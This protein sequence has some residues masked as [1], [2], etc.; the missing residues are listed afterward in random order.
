MDCERKIIIAIDGPSGSGKSTTSRMVSQ[1]LKYIYVDTGAMYRATAHY[2]L[3]NG[4]ELTENAVEALLDKINIELLMSPQGQRTLLNGNDITE[5][6]RQRDVTAAVSIVSAFPVVREYMVAL[7]QAMGKQRGVVMDGRDIGTVV[8]PDAELKIF[9][10]ASLKI[11]AERRATELQ[12]SGVEVSIK[13]VEESIMRRDFLDS[14][15]T[16]SPLLKAA[17]A[18]E[19]DTTNMTIDEQTT[20]IV[21]FAKRIICGSSKLSV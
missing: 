21:D 19:I 9:L 15:R 6:I 11:R 3:R 7:Q 20:T 17:D 1:T 13:Q 10:V 5:E 2:V 12:H 4:V 16:S 8:F 14:S 18:I